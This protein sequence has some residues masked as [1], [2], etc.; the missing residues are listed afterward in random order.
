[1]KRRKKY[2]GPKFVSLN[3][4]ADIFG[5]LSDTHAPHLHMLLTKNHAAMVNITNGCGDKEDFDLLVGA[6]NHGNVMCEMGIGNEFRESMIAGRDA[7]HAM[8]K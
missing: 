5:G 6:V 8:G 3:P 1:M 4:M 7:L 2:A